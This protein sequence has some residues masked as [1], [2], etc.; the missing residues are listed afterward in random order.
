MAYLGILIAIALGCLLLVLVANKIM[1]DRLDR[2]L[3]E[4]EGYRTVAAVSLII[5]KNVSRLQVGFQGMLL[6]SSAAELRISEELIGESMETVRR[7]IVFLEEGGE[8]VEGFRV[9]FDAL[10]QV[11]HR[12]VLAGTLPALKVAALELRTS[13]DLLE[14]MRGRYHASSIARLSGQEGGEHAS[15]LVFMHKQLAPFFS[16]FTEHANRFYVQSIGD[17]E[18]NKS[19]VKLQREVHLRILYSVSSV[20]LLALLS[21]GVLVARSTGGALRKRREVE[22]ALLRSNTLLEEATEKARALAAKAESASR[23]KSL[24]LANMSHEI[25]TPMNGIIGMTH[26]AME[27]SSEEQRQRYLAL[28]R[29]S[30]SN[31]FA[32]LND[33][34]DFSKIEAGH[35][36]LLS[37]PMKVRELVEGVIATMMPLALDKGLLLTSRIGLEVPERVVGDET[38]LRQILLNLVGNGLKFTREGE[39]WV[40]VG[41]GEAGD[42]LHFQVADSGIGIAPEDQAKVFKHFEQVDRGAG[43]IYGGTG[44][45]LAICRQ[46]VELMGGRIWVE[47]ELGAGSTFHFTV[48]LPLDKQ[49]DS[50]DQPA[51]LPLAAVSGQQILVVDDNPVNREVASMILEADNRVDSAG[52]GLEALAKIAANPYD[53]VLMDVQM[54]EL[55]GLT[56]TAIVRAL[57]EG[58]PSPRQLPDELFEPLVARLNGGHL[59]IVAITAHA[60]DDDRESCLLAGMD[61]YLTKPFMP[62]QLAGALA[63]LRAGKTTIRDGDTSFSP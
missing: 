19:R 33:I 37:R 63:G 52:D 38:R 34:L 59:P 40:T 43:H 7:A 13:L 31:L 49:E 48:S 55:D 25:R 23:A 35:M 45:G 26:L 21:V 9:N 6:A 47:S 41:Q 17:L 11:D 5:G 2:L 14:E 4:Q 54:P 30:A 1:D 51:A 61:G 20:A 42:S 3:R 16:R 28:V 56:V 44:L 22:A 18:G 27:A 36:P 46:L 32:L 8:F 24:F 10:D 53:M 57:E 39:V 15:H 29:D 12:F 62:A 60:M 50:A 58:C